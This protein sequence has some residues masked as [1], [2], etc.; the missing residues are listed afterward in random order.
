MLGSGVRGVEPSGSITRVILTSK[1]QSYLFHIPMGLLLHML[2]SYRIDSG[3]KLDIH[4]SH[5]MYTG[6]TTYSYQFDFGALGSHRTF[7][8]SRAF[9]LFNQLKINSMIKA[10][11]WTQQWGTSVHIT[12]QKQVNITIPHSLWSF[13]LPLSKTCC[14]KTEF[15]S[16]L[17]PS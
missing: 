16:Y 2:A 12:L 15:I 5:S 10:Q 4:V 8:A 17:L 14:L 3:L 6:A 13:T 1:Q 11:Q 7:L 9:A